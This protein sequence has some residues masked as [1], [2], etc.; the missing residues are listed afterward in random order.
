MY[1]WI[2]KTSWGFSLVNVWYYIWFTKKWKYCLPLVCPLRSLYFT[3]SFT[4]PFPLPLPLQWRFGLLARQWRVLEYFPLVSSSYLGLHVSLQ[5]NGLFCVCSFSF[6]SHRGFVYFF[7]VFFLFSFFKPWWCLPFIF[8]NVCT[9]Q[10]VAIPTLPPTS[11]TSA[12]NDH[13]APA[14]TGPLPSAPRDVVATLVSTR[15][16]RLTWRTPVSDPQGDNLTYS[17][18]Y[19]KE[20]INR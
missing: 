16:I 6:V 19:T 17:I 20:G 7:C 2:N 4:L 9:W 14:T 1:F 10:D 15:F 3:L 12:T 5:F 11:L 8:P 13:L 18:F